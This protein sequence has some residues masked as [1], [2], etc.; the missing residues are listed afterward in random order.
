MKKKTLKVPR[1][2][3][4]LT[5]QLIKEKD[6]LDTDYVIETEGGFLFIPLK[7]DPGRIMD[8]YLLSFDIVERELKKRPDR[9]NSYKELVEVPKDL[10]ELLP[11]SFDVIGDVAIIK[12]NGEILK[13]SCEIADALLRFNRNLKKVALDKGV[14]G[15]L[16]IRDLEPILGGEDLYTTH[17][18]NN[19]RFK[20]D[21]SKVYFSPRLA[22]ERMRIAK[23]VTDERV[24]DMF[25]GVGPFSINIARHGKPTEVVGID[26]NPECIKYM[27][28]NIKL[29]SVD[30]IV[31]AYLGDS[32]EVAPTLGVFDRIIVNLPHSSMDFLD[33]SLETIEEGVIHLYSIIEDSSVMDFIRKIH[34]LAIDAGRKV[35]IDNVRE[36][37]KYSPSQHMMAFDIRSYGRR[38]V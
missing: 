12:L 16:R 2:K 26:L 35:A 13:Y 22:T 10:E 37:H 11:S 31:E 28:L 30:D 15:D 25:A 36:V 20:L 23:Q 14:K 7:D 33:L 19:L 8:D 17:V 3:G 6:L 9:I 18:E 29:N 21:P 34:D 4:E 32:R 24:L 38:P 1:K 5:R 27:D